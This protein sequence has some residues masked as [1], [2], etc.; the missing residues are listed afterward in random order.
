LPGYATA[1][2]DNRLTREF[3]SAGR[4]SGFGTDHP[5]FAGAA[6]LKLF[7]KT[8]CLEAFSFDLRQLRV[9]VIN[10]RCMVVT[11]ASDNNKLFT[12]IS[13]NPVEYPKRGKPGKREKL[14]IFARSQ[15]PDLEKFCWQLK[16]P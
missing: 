10:V 1:N 16:E 11:V 5:V 7:L 9:A 4:R 2:K 3:Q 12:G 6:T 14:L 8:V 13:A 15:K